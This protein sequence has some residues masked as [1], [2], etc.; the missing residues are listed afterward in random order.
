MKFN[1][2]FFDNFKFSKK[3]ILRFEIEHYLYSCVYSH[4]KKTENYFGFRF[5]R[6]LIKKYTHIFFITFL[7]LSYSAFLCYPFD[8]QILCY[9]WCTKHWRVITLKLTIYWLE[10][11]STDITTLL[12][13][14][15]LIC[16]LSW[17]HLPRTFT[18]LC[19]PL[20]FANNYFISC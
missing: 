5:E 9:Y 11:I 18:G 17:D 7:H 6:F 2:E 1:F 4:E 14:G 15:P 16:V 20:S 3:M 8:I 19:C 10:L 13:V 12:S